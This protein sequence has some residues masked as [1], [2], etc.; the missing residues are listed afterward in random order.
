MLWSCRWL[1]TDIDIPRPDHCHVV[2]DIVPDY[3]TAQSPGR[4]DTPIPVIQ[5]WVDPHYPDAHREPKLRKWLEAM[6]REGWAAL[7]RFSPHEAMMLIPPLLSSEG[8][9][10]EMDGGQMQHDPVTHKGEDIAAKLH[11]A[12][13]LP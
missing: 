10:E 9:W 8:R 6:S 11:Q 2:V 7:V 12:G 1:V 4:P 13:I 5:I 3:L